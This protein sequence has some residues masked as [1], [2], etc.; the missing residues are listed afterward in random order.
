MGFLYCDLGLSG[1]AL[2]EAV[3]GGL[4]N[5]GLDIRNSLGHD[6]DGAAAVSRHIN[7]L[8]ARIFKVNSKT[9]WMQCHSV[10]LSLVIGASCNIR[11]VRNVLHQIKEISYF[12]KFQISDERCS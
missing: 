7:R 12:F 6:Y 4:I 1:E 3:L 2:A 8:S 5:L 11:C 10:R 9:V